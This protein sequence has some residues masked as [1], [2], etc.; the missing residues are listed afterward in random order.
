MT[1]RDTVSRLV[2]WFAAAILVPEVKAKL[3]VQE[4]YPVGT[5]GADFATYIRK[6]YDFFGRVVRDADIRAE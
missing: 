6:Q 5:C 3:V 4:L 1:P 2:S